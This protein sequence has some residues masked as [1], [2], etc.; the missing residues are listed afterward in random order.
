MD[1]GLK[2]KLMWSFNIG[3]LV[4]LIVVVLNTKDKP[5]EGYEFVKH[6]ISFVNQDQCKYVDAQLSMCYNNCNFPDDLPSVGPNDLPK[7]CLDEITL[8][9]RDYVKVER[10]ISY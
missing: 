5:Q 10:L 4:I 1:E 6:C 2:S 9:C 8:R 7:Y 3:V